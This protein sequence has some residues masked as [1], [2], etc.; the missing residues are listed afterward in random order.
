MNLKI[1][2]REAFL[3]NPLVVAGLALFCCLLWGSA[4]ASIKLGYDFFGISDYDISAKYLFAGIRFISA[5]FLV[6]MTAMVTKSDMKINMNQ[7]KKLFLLGFLQTFLQYAFFYVGLA[8]TS[9]TN[10]AVLS[11]MSTFTT[12]ILAHFFFESDRLTKRKSLGVSIG[13][14][15][16]I[17]L[18]FGG[19]G[20]FTFTG[21]GF[22]IIA[23]TCAAF[24]SIYIKKIV[25]GI[26]VF[27]VVVYQLFVGGAIL[28]SVG[29]IGTGGQL[30]E[31]NTGGGLA[32]L[33]L[34]LVS[35][36]AFSLWSTLLKY[37]DV[38]KVSIYKFSAPLFGVLLSFF[39]L[40]ERDLDFKLFIAI[41]LVSVGIIVIN[42]EKVK[43]A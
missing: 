8:R 19:M 12:V 28:F 29:L 7:F 41:F 30:L 3:T 1:K 40:Q 24:A 20:G 35:A 15:G 37:N 5:S 36:F 42:T 34:A 9:G 10:G 17:I 14:L 25:K 43:G 23:S 13:F 16:I 22:I 27:A 32:L 31:F 6:F 21:E 26:P 39:I 38:S 4:F 2:D 11:S 18:N 33:H